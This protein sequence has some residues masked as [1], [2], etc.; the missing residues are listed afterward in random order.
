M[1]FMAKLL[2]ND[3]NTLSLIDKNPFPGKPPKYVRALLYEYH[4]T[5]PEERRATGAWW[6]RELKGNYFPAVSLD[7]PVFKKILEREGWFP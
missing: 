6:N 4:F 5:T 7:D 2:Q 3:A 1:N